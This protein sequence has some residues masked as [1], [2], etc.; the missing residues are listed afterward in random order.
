MIG[1]AVP[2]PE[3]YPDGRQHGDAKQHEEHTEDALDRCPLHQQTLAFSW[4][5]RRPS[6]RFAN[7]KSI[8]PVYMGDLMPCV[9]CSATF[10]AKD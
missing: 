1:L 5:V 4:L 2:I 7:G 6:S 10:A 3:R 9:T 8:A